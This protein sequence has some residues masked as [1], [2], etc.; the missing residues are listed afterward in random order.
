LAAY[1]GA[2]QHHARVYQRIVA[3]RMQPWWR[4]RG[5]WLLAGIIGLHLLHAALIGWILTLLRSAPPNAE[6]AFSL[7]ARIALVV[8]YAVLTMFP[9]AV[10]L[11]AG[12]VARRA[13]ADSEQLPEDVVF[14]QP[15]FRA[16]LFAGLPI[17]V[18]DYIGQ[19]IHLAVNYGF[20]LNSSFSF[21][22]AAMRVLLDPPLVL[23]A[24]LMAFTW[25]AAF[26]VALHSTRLGWILV[27]AISM[28]S[29][30]SGTL[31]EVFDAALAVR[32]QALH[33]E[34]SPGIYL[35]YMGGWVL[36]TLLLVFSLRAAVS[37]SRKR[38]QQWLTPLLL[39]MLFSPVSLLAYAGGLLRDDA[40]F[41]ISGLVSSPLGLPY[42]THI[43]AYIWKQLGLAE[44]S[45]LWIVERLLGVAIV[46]GAAL[47]PYWL[48]SQWL[49][50]RESTGSS[51]D[52]AAFAAES[53][54]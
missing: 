46:T 50:R 2:V 31:A 54:T 49:T 16:M 42:G 8:E 28:A 36:G 23:A 44:N 27:L 10:W 6:F 18:T 4:K 20:R 29:I 25:I 14:R 39:L 35:A 12:N 17:L 15:A 22:H 45:S 5:I 53:A 30:A 51:A 41:V 40:Y 11:V 1:N 21:E 48:I 37:G 7:A 33:W 52:D 47:I 38:S 3:Q 19:C 9:L 32:N 34:D 26:S 13:V 43:V 24:L